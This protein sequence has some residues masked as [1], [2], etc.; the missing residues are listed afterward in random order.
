M[1][2]SG[3]GHGTLTQIQI[4]G[5]PLTDSN[6]IVNIPLASQNVGGN[7]IMSYTDKL[8]LDGISPYAQVNVLESVKVNGTALTITN[9]A[10][11]VP[12]PTAL[13][14][15]T[16]DATHR[17]VTDTLIGRWNG[18]YNIVPAAAYNTGNELADKA[19]VNSSVAT[20]TA[21]FRGT[22]TTATTESAFLVWANGL[23][24]DLND[25][26]FW[27]TTDSVG[28]VVYKRYKYDGTQWAF[29]YDLNNS[30][31]TADQWA[32]INSGI[33]GS[34]VTSYSNHIAN[35]SNPHNVTKTQVGLGNVGNF[36]AVST[37]ASQGLTTTEQSNARANIGLGTAAT[38][39]HTDYVT[40]I[41]YDSVNLKLQQSKGDAAA[42]DI[43]TFGSNAFN[44]D[45]YAGGTAVTL[46]GTSK[47]KNTASFYAPTS[48]G[49]AGQ[50]LKSTG[51]AP[52][53]ED[54][55]IPYIEWSG[56]TSEGPKLQIFT[57]G[58]GSPE[59]AV[60]AASAAASGV[61][62]VGT[63]S[64]G[65]AK[66][67][68]STITAASHI[69]S[70]N[71]NIE[72]LHGGV[73]AMG[74]AN[75]SINSGGGQGTLTQIKVNG[76]ALS[77]VNGVVNIP[78][79]VAG[80]NGRDGAMSN[81]DKTKL[82]GIAD[83]ANNYTLPVAT[84]D[85][86][87][88]IR[89]GY[90]A[91]GK[92][93]AVQLDNNNK[94]Y[95]YV[96][97]SN[98]EYTFYNLA[99]QNASGT[100][101]DIYKPTTSPSKTIK[102]GSNVTISAASNVI[103][104][105]AIDTTY[106]FGAGD[107]NGQIKVTPSGGSAQNIDVTGLDTAA[108]HA[109][110]D[111]AT[112]GHTHT[113]SIASSTGTNQLNLNFGTKYALTAG[114]TSFIF[115]MPTA[116]ISNGVITIGSNNITPLTGITSNM[117]TT[118]LGYTPFNNADFTQANIQSTLGISDWALAA[119]KPSYA[120]SEITGT[121]SDSQIPT[122]AISKISGLQTALDGK[123]ATSLK[124]AANGLAE[125]DANGLVPSSQLPSYVDDVLEYASKSAFPA[126]GTSGKIYVALDTNLTYRW[127][128][129]AYTEISP[130]LALGETSSTAYRGDRGKT[131]YDHATENK[132]GAQNSGF[133]KFSVTAQGHIS[134]VSAVAASDLTT[135]IGS[136]TYAPY[137]AN[138]YLPLNGG[139][140]N[141]LTNA[142][143]ISPTNASSFQDGIILNDRG[144]GASEGLRIR[145]TSASYTTGHTFNVRPDTG[146][147]YI[148]ANKIWHEGNDGSGS[149]LDADK[150]DGQ[151][152]SYYATSSSVT[153]LQGYFTNGVANN[154]DKV[155]GYHA[156]ELYVRGEHRYG[157]ENYI[158]DIAKGGQTTR[159][160][161]DTI[162][163]SGTTT[164]TY[165]F[166]KTTEN[167][168][169]DE[170]YTFGFYVEGYTGT[171]TWT[172]YCS[173]SATCI[174]IDINKNGWVWGTG[175]AIPSGGT[176]TSILLID[177]AGSGNAR[178]L[179]FSKFI[180]VKGYA[181]P[182]YVKAM[183]KQ[184]IG[185][186]SA[187]TT[188][189]GGATTPV[190]FSNGVPV[191][192]TSYA[193]ASVNYAN[194]AGAVAWTNV[195]SRPT[196]L[197]DFTD[198]LGSSPTHTHSQYLEKVTYEWNKSIAFGSTGYLL[199]GKFP[200]YDSNIT[201]DIDSTT[202]TTYH[203][204]LVIATQN[205]NTSRGGTYVC[206]VYGDA[207]NTVTS[208]F[209]VQY[210]SGSN[211]FNVYFKPQRWSKNLVHIRA[212]ALAAAPTESEICTNVDSVPTTDL[213]TVT[214]ALTAT[215]LGI[216]AKAA[217]SDKLDG[218]D[219]SYYATASSVTTL[220]GYF[221]SGVAN[222]AA[223]LTTVSKTAWG[224]TFWTSGGIPATISGDM[225]NVGNISF[226][227]TGKNIGGIAY[228]DTTNARLGI[229]TSSP[230]GKLD[231]NGT[232]IGKGVYSN[233]YY[234]L[235]KSG[236][237]GW[238]QCIDNG[239]NHPIFGYGFA[240]SGY[241]CTFTGNNVHIVAGTTWSSRTNGIEILANGN[242]GIGK[243]SPAY[244]L[245]VNGDVQATNFRGALIG[246]ADTAT[247]L[248][249]VSK[250]AWGQT[251][252]TSGGIPAT[253]SGDMTNVGNIAF[254]ASGKNIGG[255][256][257][258]D[259][260]NRKVEVGTSSS[261][262]DLCSMGG[263]SAMGIASMAI[264]SVSGVAF[265]QKI[266]MN[267]Q[268]Y[269][270]YNGVIT[271]PNYT[272]TY[273]PSNS[274][275]TTEA[276][277]QKGAKT[278]YTAIINSLPSTTTVAGWGYKKGMVYTTSTA[279]SSSIDVATGADPTY[280]FVTNTSQSSLIIT[281]TTSGAAS[282]SY[283]V[284]RYIMIYNDRS[285]ATTVQFFDP[286]PNGVI[287]PADSVSIP[288]N[289]YMEFSIIHPASNAKCMV[290]WSMPLKD[291]TTM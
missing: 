1:A 182:A 210:S 134:G 186:A 129:S 270:A 146:D 290:T 273:N 122:L 235:P 61:V 87:G 116:S 144:S 245:D 243:Q 42:T 52:A 83:H 78:L 100:Q 24:H 11:D 265:A 155:D 21:T 266:T 92:Y 138:G 206:N 216:S 46:N 179:T 154:A 254:S 103:T 86:L 12:V 175:T 119:S 99:F 113:T 167:L 257:Y 195:S 44:S 35:T 96:P 233:G 106:T 286:T 252:W 22:N 70:T 222:S 45:T 112:S 196:K 209:V 172:F 212:V 97:W 267:G 219:G 226:S 95:V 231:V 108:F 101:V 55:A 171:G 26:V 73:S 271:L 43:V 151:E 72:A 6:G 48:A 204:T 287:A 15:L 49:T 176:A 262:A 85:A 150:L 59:V 53:W 264:N 246:N 217:D 169:P 29:E 17:L 123:L 268:N 255:L 148:D 114:G 10:V 215:F 200:M 189:A 248:T 80:T 239:G 25:Y 107:D 223:K 214:N 109:A 190:Y 64:F 62:I 291:I 247:A 224:Q 34:L 36:L 160:D 227:A 102:A 207:T 7:G 74:I 181:L 131:A 250:T 281:V 50:Y 213:L 105:A 8:K 104:I 14:Q 221:T 228:F 137:N 82:D 193:N 185:Y 168:V 33:T 93:Y 130:S 142:L 68:D 153:T 188:D 236:E 242:V 117:V 289:S 39:A 174:K 9:K 269:E 282:N 40:S 75:L 90:G 128:G 5:V 229:G 225:T 139:E 272:A 143:Y 141:A 67:F 149:G 202:S 124:G 37:V 63:Q 20:A 191:A 89:I 13:S 38:H 28:N 237:S 126:T 77:D 274:G 208:A 218:Q 240:A 136:T 163:T 220:Q 32:A 277:S 51:G 127:S 47:A 161:D 164:D 256:L 184:T 158:Y 88:G 140:N 56:G 261:T 111:F 183:R 249:T 19:F 69:Q 133:Y 192:C 187:L 16:D 205:I 121:A 57:D 98:T 66:S 230:A 279:S 91:S 232:I 241:D 276:L 2:I 285:S 263:V 118:A 211:K 115:T 275:S 31:F 41:S 170:I 278:M 288:A 280:Q 283:G 3:G 157:L 147:A 244:K 260:T 81:A 284:H 120:F 166:I 180:M 27:Q 23:T 251:F 234:Y 94:A 253:I 201:I 84:S 152:G 259:T 79:A 173:N 156:S 135:L 60:P 65:G 125:L 165:F 162:T 194:S 71:G 197:S 238:L 76:T 159:V 178:A 30:S 18:V 58:G 203:G 110:S 199:I 198:D 132:S 54:F 258:F 177:D 145:F 4:A